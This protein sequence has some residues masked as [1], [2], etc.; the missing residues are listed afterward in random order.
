MKKQKGEAVLT[1]VAVLIILVLVALIFAV[2]EFFRY[3]ARAGA[4]NE[5][6]LNEIKIKQ[7]EQLI[8]VE[9]QKAEIRVEEAKGIAHA[10]AWVK[11]ASFSRRPY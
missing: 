9:T 7:Q 6:T 10:F 3:Q 5:V 2:P 1:V 11:K 8:K 4:S